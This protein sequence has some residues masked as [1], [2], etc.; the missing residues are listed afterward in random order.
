MN[1]EPSPILINPVRGAPYLW[2]PRNWS[3][4]LA[5]FLKKDSLL[6][7]GRVEYYKQFIGGNNAH[8]ALAAAQVEAAGW[9]KGGG[10]R[11]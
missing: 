8:R 5:E 1:Q 10:N 7:R 3:E 9:A 11:E 6:P 2:Q 4:E